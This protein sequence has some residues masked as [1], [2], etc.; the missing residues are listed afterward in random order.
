MDYT[1]HPT[2]STY[3]LIL[4]QLDWQDQPEYDTR[5]NKTLLGPSTPAPDC[6]KSIATNHVPGL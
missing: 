5:N 2:A 1:K 3:N 6:V 4:H